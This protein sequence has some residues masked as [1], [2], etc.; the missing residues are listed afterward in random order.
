MTP[1]VMLMPDSAELGRSIEMTEESRLC[2][3][4]RE[5]RELAESFWPARNL[6]SSLVF[7][8]SD[9]CFEREKKDDIVD[10]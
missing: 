2:R 10:P 7:R 1:A 5:F 6:P 9:L 4:A 8:L 3:D